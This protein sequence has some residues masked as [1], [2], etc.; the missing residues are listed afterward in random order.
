[1]NKKSLLSVGDQKKSETIRIFCSSF[2]IF[3]PALN[4]IQIYNRKKQ[5]RAEGNDEKNNEANR[6][7]FSHIYSSFQSIILLLNFFSSLF[8]QCFSSFSVRFFCLLRSACIKSQTFF[9]WKTN[10]LSIHLF[11]LH[12]N[13]QTYFGHRQCSTQSIRS[14]QIAMVRQHH[15]HRTQNIMK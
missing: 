2:S 13:W 3:F 6:H 9:I 11:D 1:M 15:A 5:E 7:E 12:F 8:V 14:N 4:E 10:S